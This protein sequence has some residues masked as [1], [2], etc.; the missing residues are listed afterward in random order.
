VRTAQ[1][2]PHLL[3]TKHRERH[4]GRRPALPQGL[5]YIQPNCD[6]SSQ[7]VIYPA[8]LCIRIEATQLFSKVL[9]IVP[10][11][12][13]PYQ[14]EASVL[15][16]C[17]GGRI[18]HRYGAVEDSLR[19]SRKSLIQLMR[20]TMAAKHTFKSGPGVHRIALFDF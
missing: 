17:I 12:E 1:G 19:V 14:I 13:M 7:T 2:P 15:I 8:K 3:A 20:R 6:I 9:I 11:Y 5:R 4:Q 18:R 10:P 16:A